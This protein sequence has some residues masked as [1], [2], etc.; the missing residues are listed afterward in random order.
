MKLIR[1]LIPLMMLAVCFLQ[2]VVAQE[3]PV[4]IVI[5]DDFAGN[6][7]RLVDRVTR[8]REYRDILTPLV[9][10]ADAIGAREVGSFRLPTTRDRDAII[11][12]QQG[13]TPTPLAPLTEVIIPNLRGEVNRAATA[14]NRALSTEQIIT[15]RADINTENCAVTT[16]GES[17]FSTGGASIFSTG[18]ASIFSTGGAGIFSTGGAGYSTQPHGVRVEALVNEL[19]TQNAPDAQIIVRRVDTAGFTTSV[20]LERLQSEL[21]TISSSSPGADV[22]VN[23]SFAVVPCTSIGTLAAYDAMMRQ[24]DPTVAG[25]M[26]A[27]QAFFDEIVASGVLS[28]PLNSS[29]AMNTFLTQSCNAAEQRCSYTS[30]GDVIPVAAAGNAAAAY[31]YFPAAWSSVIAVSASEDSE[32]FVPTGSL[33]PYSNAGTVMMPGTW[34]SPTAIEIGT[35]FAAP[36]YSFLMALYLLG[37]DNDFCHTGAPVAPTLPGQWG[38]NPP[39]SPA[40][41]NDTIC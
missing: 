2:P 34:I 11:A 9:L 30:L 22:V 25:D 21:N 37:R 36:R 5:V 19:I 14:I 40:V 20:I 39:S 7:R 23:M 18:G 8:L 15:G 16:E 4:Y 13:A 38:I 24:L 27:L 41:P 17:I 26:A 12:P 1:V 35:S 31:P 28:A 3:S 29:D 10:Q 32:S 6:M 33:A